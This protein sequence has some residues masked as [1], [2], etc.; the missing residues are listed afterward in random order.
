MRKLQPRIH[1]SAFLVL[2]LFWVAFNALANSTLPSFNYRGV[3]LKAE[4]LKYRPH[5]DV[6]YPTVVRVDQRVAKPLAKYYMYYAPHDAPG[7]ICLAVADK[8]EG[9]W[10]EFTNNPLISREWTTN[11]RVSHVSGPD[12]IWNEEEQKLFLY[13]HGENDVTR[14]ASSEDGVHFRYEGTVIDSRMFEAGTTEASYGRVFGQRLPSKNN[15]Y[16]MLL[17]GNKNNTRNIYLAWSNDGRKWETQRAPLLRPPAGTDQI[18]GAIHLLVHGKHYLIFHAHN[19][20]GKMNEGYDLYAVETDTNLIPLA[21]PFKY[22]D[23]TFV[24]PTNSAV[25]SPFIL[26]DAGKLYMYFNMGPRLQNQIALGIATP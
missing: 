2:I 15:R 26:E 12:V 11:Y 25:M 8:P 9:P 18:A 10:I 17:M 4:S 22:I 7:G 5:N 21:T 14:L 20:G 3:I 16:V 24:S 1:W 19:S 23:R 6:I 13:F